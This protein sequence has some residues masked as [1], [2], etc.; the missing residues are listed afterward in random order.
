MNCNFFVIMLVS[1]YL[2]MTKSSGWQ[3]LTPFK[4]DWH[5]KSALPKFRWGLR[6]HEYFTCSKLHTNFKLQCLVV[7]VYYII[8]W[9]DF[10]TIMGMPLFSKCYCSSWWYYIIMLESWWCHQ[11]E[12]FSAL[13]TLG[14]GISPV[15]GEFPAQRPATRSF[16]ISVICALNKR[17]SKQ[18]WG[19]WFE[20]PARSL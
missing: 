19:W 8:R 11:M 16:D 9:I 15:T 4:V 2:I 5:H 6:R 20:T 1:R 17:L 7:K 14:A 12:T 3:I 10:N 18:S 13:L